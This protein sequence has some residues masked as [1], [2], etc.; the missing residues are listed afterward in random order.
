MA[1]IYFFALLGARILTFAASILFARLLSP[2]DFGDFILANSNALLCSMLGSYWLSTVALRFIP[3]R[4]GAEAGALVSTFL[5]GMLLSTLVAIIVALVGVLTGAMPIKMIVWP[6]FAALIPLLIASDLTAAY[7]NGAHDA[8]SYGRLVLSRSIVGLFASSTLIFFGFGAFGALA[9]QFIGLCAGLIAPAVIAVWKPARWRDVS[10]ELLR[11][12]FAFGAVGSLVY[13]LYIIIQVENRNFIAAHFGD[14]DAGRFALVF[15]T[16][17]APIGMIVSAVSLDRVATLYR[18]ALTGEDQFGAQIG[19][20]IAA[21]LFFS[22]PYAVGGY[23]LAEGLGRAIFGEAINAEVAAYSSLAPI[24]GALMCVLSTLLVSLL[25]LDRRRDAAIA[26]AASIFLNAIAPKY[27]SITGDIRGVAV[28]SLA[29]IAIVVAALLFWM[30]ASLRVRLNLRELG[31]AGFGTALM[32]GATLVLA[33][34][35]EPFRSAF[36]VLTGVAVFLAWA[37]ISGSDTLRSVL[38]P[39]LRLKR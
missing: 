25:V 34:L 28:A 19:S 31:R 9:G 15:D 30:L 18:D 37:S 1:H 4:E 26:L 7:F 21:T 5:A 24:H 39:V 32:A 2:A 11:R 20:F 22:L 8:R 23:L 35:H 36:A 6:I 38:P 29:I 10:G 17:Y 13:S 3:L 33:P 14:A 27:L 12:I 16:Y